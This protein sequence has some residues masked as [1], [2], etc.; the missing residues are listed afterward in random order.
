MQA[1]L[2]DWMDSEGHHP[3]RSTIAT[4]VQA[5]RG[6]QAATNGVS[7]VPSKAPSN[8]ALLTAPLAEKD[9]A[10]APT[11]APDL[12]PASLLKRAVALV[13]ELALALPIWRYTYAHAPW[14]APAAMTL[15]FAVSLYFFKATPGQL[16][17]SLRSSRKGRPVGMGRGLLRSMAVHGG[18]LS[19]GAFFG[20]TYASHP[21]SSW[22]GLVALVWLVAVMVSAM[23][24]LFKRRTTLI[25]RI[26][27][28]SVYQERPPPQ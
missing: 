5:L 17:M 12:P 1:D 25:D 19:L 16:V 10:A 23:G 4:T 20:A 6:D 14:A 9:M 26:L 22:I 24:V 2:A 18:F 8:P 27:G 15:L 11:A 7:L 28:I 21:A 13:L 3:S